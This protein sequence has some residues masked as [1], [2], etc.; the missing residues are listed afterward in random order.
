MKIGWPWARAATPRPQHTH[1][2]WHKKGA[3]GGPAA[4]LGPWPRTALH[5]GHS[6]WGCCL[7][8]HSL[9]TN[10]GTSRVVHAAASLVANGCVVG[11]FYFNAVSWLGVGCMLQCRCVSLSAHAKL[12]CNC[13]APKPNLPTHTPMPCPAQPQSG[14][15][16]CSTTQ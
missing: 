2:L 13:T 15:S 9:P 4:L 16:H 11:C 12:S 14:W 10:W 8:Q 1:C 7:P 5:Q 6:G 3:L